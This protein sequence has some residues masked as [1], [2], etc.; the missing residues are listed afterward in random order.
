[1]RIYIIIGA[2]L[3]IVVALGASHRW[4]YQSGRTAERA[5][6]LQHSMDVIKERFNTNAEINAL[7]DAGLCRAIG[8]VWLPDEKLCN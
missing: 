2:A 6:A 1:M 4:A 3:A 5:A 7:D 8:G